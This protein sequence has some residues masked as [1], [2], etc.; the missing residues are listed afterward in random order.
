M[1][2]LS[3]LPLIMILITRRGLTQGKN[4]TR[5]ESFFRVPSTSWGVFLFPLPSVAT[6]MDVTPSRIGAIRLGETETRV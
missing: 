4:R 3:P 2:L 5:G 1:L 6:A